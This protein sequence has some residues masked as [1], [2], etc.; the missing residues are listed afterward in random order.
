[1]ADDELLRLDYGETTQLLRALTEVRFRLLAF[2]PTIAGAAIAFLAHPSSAA[3]LMAV[4]LVGLG[5][6][7]GIFMYELRNTQLYD[8]ALHRAMFLEQRLRV[9]SALGGEGIGGLYS[10]RPSRPMRLFGI[11]TVWHVRAIV[12]VYATALGG[13]S[14]LVGWG[15]LRELGAAHSRGWGGAVAAV[16]VVLTIVEGQRLERRPARTGSAAADVARP[17]AT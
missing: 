12:L 14:Y 10:E 9:P 4:G 13:W 2:V 15:V 7:V 6:T 5:A 17:A 1:M 8:A 16:A 3:E 11:V